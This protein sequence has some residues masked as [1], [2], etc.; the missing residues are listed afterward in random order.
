MPCAD[1]F[2]G[3]T[4]GTR[5]CCTSRAAIRRR[6]ESTYGSLVIKVKALDVNNL[7]RTIIFITALSKSIST[8]LVSIAITRNGSDEG[9]LLCLTGAEGELDCV[10]G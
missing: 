4:C 5:V 8:C 1:S 2:L 9:K 7:S 6:R 10:A 3:L